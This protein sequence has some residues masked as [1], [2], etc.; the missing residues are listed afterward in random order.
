MNA[1]L[2]HRGEVEETSMKVS[3]SHCVLKVRDLDAM[4]GFYCDALGFAV[5]DRGEVAPERRI[6]FLSGSSS[7]H[8]QFGSLEGRGDGE[9]TSLEHNAFRVDSI[10]DVQAM[11]DWVASD[12]RVGDG[13]PVTHGNAVSVYFKDPE[14]NGIEI[15]ADTP[16]HVQQPQARGWDP[17]L[18]PADVLA[19]VESQFAD[20]PEFGPMEDY[21]AVQAEA[22]GE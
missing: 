20:Q 18:A 13:F 15:F 7:D 10:E 19:T 6:A 16:W 12:E 1:A 21:R 9:A 17:S 2:G 3:W 11:I 4:V 5:A 22:F 14:G 8:H